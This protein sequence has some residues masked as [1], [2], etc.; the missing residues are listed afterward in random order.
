MAT[1]P[2]AGRRTASVSWFQM[3]LTCAGSTDPGR[4]RDNNEDS[5]CIREDL[6]L[7]LV[8]DGMGGHV[9]G[10]VASRLVVEEVE[11]SVAATAPVGALRDEVPALTAAGGA[12]HR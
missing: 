11:R 12:G 1:P 5:F 9:A 7:F 8:A 2:G 10:E 6:G 4:R 3:R